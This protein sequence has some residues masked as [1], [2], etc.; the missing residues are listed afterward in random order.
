MYYDPV[1]RDRGR[2]PRRHQGREE[3]AAAHDRRPGDA[4]PRGPG[5]HHPRGALRGQARLRDRA[6][7]ARRRSREM[8]ALLDNVPQSRT[9]RRDDQAAADRPCAGQ[10]SSSCASWACTAASSRCSTSCSTRRSATTGARS[11]SASRSPT[12]TAASP[13]ASRWRRASCSPAMLWHDVR[14]GWQPAPGARASRRSRRCRR[15]STRCSTRASATSPAA[16]SSAADMREIW[17]MQPRFERRAGNSPFTPGRAAALSRRLRLPAPAR[18]RRRGRRRAG[19]HGGRSSFEASDDERRRTARRRCA[20]SAAAPRQARRGGRGE[21]R[22]RSRRGR[23][24]DEPRRAGE[25][26]TRR[27][28]TPLRPTARRAAQAA[29]APPPPPSRP[30]RRAERRPMAAPAVAA[31]IDAY[32]GLGA[33]LGDRAARR[34]RRALDALAALPQTTLVA[35]SSLYRI[36]P[37]DAAG[38]DY[39]NAVAA[40]A[41]GARRRSTLLRALQAIE[42]AHGRERPYRNAPRTLDL[43]LLLHGD[44]DA[45]ERRAD[46]AASAPARARVRAAAARRDRAGRARRPRTRCARGVARGGRRAGRR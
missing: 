17:M 38:G 36:A 11:S 33:N 19:R 43:D 35:R 31:P 40:P 3:E 14:D 29:P 44:R 26:A 5:A 1:T 10:R 46:A 8:A 30:A 42:R 15:R 21:R 39:L 28:T 37:V 20:S 9:V 4:L 32:V 7:D 34:S 24:A 16:A 13:R 45:R 23:G 6:E 18:R 27:P 12:P 2:L 41:H 25:A 22:Q